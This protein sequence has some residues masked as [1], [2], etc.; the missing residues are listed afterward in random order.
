MQKVKEYPDPK[1]IISY[2]YAITR[3]EWKK[4]K[5]EWTDFTRKFQF[6]HEFAGNQKWIKN[7]FGAIVEKSTV[8]FFIQWMVGVLK[9]PWHFVSGKRFL[10]EK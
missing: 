7:D 10:A 5:E 1:N 6:G 4:M 2:A 3:E 8:A 9:S